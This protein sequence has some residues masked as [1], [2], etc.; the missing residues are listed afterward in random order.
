MLATIF[1]LIV[2]LIITIEIKII[3]IEL[4]KLKA[5]YQNIITE[6]QTITSKQTLVLKQ[7]QA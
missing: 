6:L 1:I 5:K 7:Y 3:N 4:N 2:I